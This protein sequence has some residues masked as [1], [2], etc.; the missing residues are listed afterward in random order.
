MIEKD[1]LAYFRYWLGRYQAGAGG[2]G[3]RESGAKCNIRPSQQPGPG[4][5]AGPVSGAFRQLY[6][7]AADITVTG[8]NSLY[9]IVLA[10]C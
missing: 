9:C 3:E 7:A 8:A 5:G 1:A 4:R 2:S 10:K 6:S